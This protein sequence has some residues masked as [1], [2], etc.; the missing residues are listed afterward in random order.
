[1]AVWCDC[2]VYFG[3]PCFRQR[4]ATQ[5]QWFELEQPSPSPNLHLLVLLFYSKLLAAN[6]RM[7]WAR[8]MFQPKARLLFSPL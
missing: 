1:M 3:F 2:I 4:R 8:N 6:Y 5:L 7:A